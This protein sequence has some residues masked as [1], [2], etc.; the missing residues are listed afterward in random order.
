LG[1]LAT[2]VFVTASVSSA[3]VS[4]HW[5]SDPRK[6]CGPP[7][8]GSQ[9]QS[10]LQST[11]PRAVPIGQTYTGDVVWVGFVDNFLAS[12]ESEQYRVCHTARR[13][14]SC[15]GDVLRGTHWDWRRVRILPP[16][17]RHGSRSSYVEFRWFVDGS[18][19]AKRRIRVYE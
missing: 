12:G 10:W 2:I 16:L 14:W 19:R 15:H 4:G 17:I 1:A 13:G 5:P 6:P 3:H 7:P 11:H 18:R 9:F 8:N